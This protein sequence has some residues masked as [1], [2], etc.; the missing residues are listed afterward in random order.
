MDD[1]LEQHFA[2]GN[3]PSDGTP[4]RIG[5]GVIVS[6]FRSHDIDATREH[7]RRNYGEHSRVI[8]G[9]G[10]FLY[11]AHAVGTDRVTTAHAERW[12]SQTLRAA[13]QHPTLFVTQE[14]G[15]SVRIARRQHALGSSTAFFAAPDHEYVRSGP[16]R[17][18]AIL[19][20]DRDLLEQ[21]IAGRSRVR[22]PRWALANLPLR[23][24]EGRYAELTQ[25]FRQLRRAGADGGSWDG[26]GTSAAFEAAVADWLAGLLLDA[27]GAR[28]ITEL[29]LQRIVR[30]ERWIDQH[31]AESLS[32]DQLCAVVGVSRRSLQKG[33]LATR[34]QTPIE[35]VTSRR[36]TAARRRLEQG[37]SRRQV[38]TVALDCGFRHLGRFA[39]SYRAAFGESP[40]ATARAARPDPAGP[41]N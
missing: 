16:A 7:V 32:L 2:P 20:V 9:R 19:R 34:G 14:P 26:Y 3:V 4:V 41:P 17:H 27:R 35:L 31:L 10:D 11:A 5:N 30:L 24:T 13:V 28:P 37:S 1:G 29:G 39:A 15:E 18:A 36:L 23:M 38:A 6:G 40:S 22:S 12:L 8:H 25:F 21:A 33:L